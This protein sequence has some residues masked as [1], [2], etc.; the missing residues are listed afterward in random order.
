M[1]DVAAWDLPGLQ[2]LWQ[3][4]RPFCH[5]ELDGLLGRPRLEELRRGFAQEPH[6]PY[7]A[8]IYEFM[9][10]G[11]PPSR[12]E[13]LAFIAALSSDAVLRAVESI[14]GQKL[15][16]AEGRGYVY[17]P[18]SY[19]LPHSDCR[20]GL[21]RAVAFVYYLAPDQ[22]LQGGELE[23]FDVGFE[24]GEIVRTTPALRIQPRVDRLALFE[25]SD[26]S[27]HQVREVLSGGR[28][29]IAGWFYR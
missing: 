29:S 16:H 7:G 17:L 10:S 9:G 4:A 3:A 8:E 20:E 25:V 1:I 22:G 24:N 11:E 6:W 26:R 21:G 13:L 19:L 2:S 18:G 12:P 14:S 5:V 15:S 28:A 27:L 23:L